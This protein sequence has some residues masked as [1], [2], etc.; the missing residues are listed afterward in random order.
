MSFLEAFFFRS[1][2][3]DSDCY[4]IWFNFLSYAWSTMH[5]KGNLCGVRSHASIACIIRATSFHVMSFDRWEQF[6]ST[7]LTLR[8]EALMVN[9]CTLIPR[10][11]NV[12][13]ANSF[14]TSQPTSTNLRFLKLFVE[15]RR[16]YT[17]HWAFLNSH[18]FLAST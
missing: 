2:S 13:G 1:I 14:V 6:S 16:L 18:I 11:R 10:V 5:H 7:G 4:G 9:I 3:K 8:F 12:G 15:T 17:K